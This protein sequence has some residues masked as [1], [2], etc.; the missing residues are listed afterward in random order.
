MFHAPGLHHVSWQSSRSF[1][2]DLAPKQKINALTAFLRLDS[3]QGHSDVKVLAIKFKFRKRT[4]MCYKGCGNLFFV[5]YWMPVGKEDLTLHLR[6]STEKYFTAIKHD[7]WTQKGRRLVAAMLGNLFRCFRLPA[8]PLL[9][10]ALIWCEG[11]KTEIKCVIMRTRTI[12]HI[13]LRL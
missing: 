2:C 11:M 9:F 6:E 13:L 10:V 8:P 3:Y 7:T 1:F 4:F 5:F 12:Q